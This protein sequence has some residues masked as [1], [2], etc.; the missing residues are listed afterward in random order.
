M[1]TRHKVHT[2]SSSEAT[3]VSPVGVHG[4]V[5]ITIQNLSSEKYIYVGGEGVTTSS[6]GYRIDPKSAWSVELNGNDSLYVVSE[7]NG[8]LSAVMMLSLESGS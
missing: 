7:T 5:D 2:L 4:G 6:F 1:A 8:I 3:L